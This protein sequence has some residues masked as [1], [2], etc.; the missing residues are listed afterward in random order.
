METLAFASAA[1]VSAAFSAGGAS[2]ATTAVAA[3]WAAIVG[4]T[5]IA[6]AALAG[7]NMALTALLPKPAGVSPSIQQI[8]VKDPV[9]ARI[10]HYGRVK[11]SGS[12]G[13]LRVSDENPNPT[14]HDLIKIVLLAAHEIDA[15]EAHYLAGDPYEI[16]DAGFVLGNVY[17]SD[18]QPYV[19]IFPHFGTDT[20]LADDFMLARFP[21]VWTAEHRGRG[22]AYSVIRYRGPETAEKVMKVFPQGAPVYQAL[23]RGARL[24]DPTLDGTNGGSGPC[25][26][27]NPATWVWSDEQRL[28]MLDFLTHPDCYAKGW[29]RD[30]AIADR[31][32]AACSID[33]PSW[34]AQILRGRETVDLKDGGTEARWRCA[35]SVD[36]AN[37]EKSSAFARIRNAG[38]ARIFLTGDG[39]IGCAGGGWDAPTVAIDAEAHLI[40]A[41]LGPV[42]RMAGYNV[43]KAKFMSPAHDYVEQEMDPWLDAAAIALAGERESEIDLTAVPSHG[44]ARRLAKIVMAR[45]NAAFAGSMRTKLPGLQ[46]V[47]EEAVGFT[48]AELDAGSGDID[49]PYW[50]EG[51]ISADLETGTVALALKKADPASYAWDAD[52]EEGTAPLVPGELPGPAFLID[53]DDN[54]LFDDN[55]DML[56]DEA[57]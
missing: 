55:D 18:D 54:L 19:Q 33:W 3:N 30:T 57:A 45:D 1:V 8:E 44:Q 28:I 42:D 23:I 21:D 11:V 2:V 51:E 48:F 14:E 29:P 52:T 35:T 46:A 26:I 49:G 10:R 6:T 20:Q 7:A 40:D 56:I 43:L 5:V 47:R 17:S 36:L 53:D 50:V 15:I 9:A 39:K 4:P 27:D 38:D 12:I 37:E 32:L 22:I 16:D 34:R 25:R 24:Y 13:F 31:T 41:E